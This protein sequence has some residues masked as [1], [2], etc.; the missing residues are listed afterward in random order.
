LSLGKDHLASYIATLVFHIFCPVRILISSTKTNNLSAFQRAL[1]TI[2]QSEFES[3]EFVHYALRSEKGKDNNIRRQQQELSEKV[4]NSVKVSLGSESSVLL[5]GP[6]FAYATQRLSYHAQR[7]EWVNSKPEIQSKKRE[8]QAYDSGRPFILDYSE[9]D[10]FDVVVI[11]GSYH[12]LQQVDLLQKCKELMVDGGSLIILGEF[13]EDDSERIHSALPNLSSLTQLS[14]RLGFE[15]VSETDLTPDAIE[16]V[17]V[18]KK[19]LKQETAFPKDEDKALIFNLLDEAESEFSRG[20]RCYKLFRFIKV[21]KQAGDY[22]LAHYGDIESFD[23]QEICEL[24]EK[25]FETAFDHEIW[26]WKYELGNGKCV[27][28]RSE[29]SGPIVSHYGGAP[30]QI[31][32]FGKMDK[33]IQV[34]DVMVLPEVRLQYG[35]N[36]L[37]FKTAATF[38]E[39][40]IGNTVGHLLGFGFPNKKAMNIALRLGLYEKTDDFLEFIF[41]IADTKSSVEYKL[42]DIDPKNLAH[43]SAVDRLWDSMSPAFENGI[44]GVRNWEYVKYRYFDHPRGISGEFKRLFLSDGHGDICAAFFLKEHDQCNLVMDI[45]CPFKDITQY[46]LKLSLLLN[47]VRLKIWITKG[48]SKTLEVAGIIENDLGIEIPSNYWNPGPSSE[49][50]YGAWWL[51]AGDMDFM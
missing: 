3:C 40:E 17:D 21:L 18:F 11:E 8:S 19:I 30:R 6:S 44:I 47:E 24:F 20:R 28:A 12:Y 33:A 25:S 26:R 1:A 2:L 48:W 23:H 9:S 49:I 51:T 41:P 39:R 31:N 36:S 4:I 16:S 43:Q 10:D 35:K 13:L 27:V 22:E 46:I 32:Y 42:L 7:V 15:L 14:D 37:F 29:P 5:S 45:I 50:L 34:C 38:L